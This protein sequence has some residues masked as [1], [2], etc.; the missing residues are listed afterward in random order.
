MSAVQEFNK[1]SSSSS[2]SSISEEATVEK[3]VDQAVAVWEPKVWPAAS[4]QAIRIATDNGSGGSSS[5]ITL[6][7]QFDSDPAYLAAVTCDS[8][9]AATDCTNVLAQFLESKLV[10]ARVHLL[11]Q[12][13]VS[14]SFL[15]YIPIGGHERCCM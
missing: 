12:A 6:D 15:Y 5:G 2:S 11:T 8:T 9:S 1:S 13:L 4:V 7:L 14:W 10:K 3:L